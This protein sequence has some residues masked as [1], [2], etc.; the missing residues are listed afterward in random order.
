MIGLQNWESELLAVASM[1]ILSVYLRQRGSPE[2][3]PVGA[4][5]TATVSYTLC[6]ITGTRRL[7]KALSVA[8]RQMADATAEQPLLRQ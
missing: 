8:R 4:A 7:D 2:S 3:K 5:Q 1:A 6:V